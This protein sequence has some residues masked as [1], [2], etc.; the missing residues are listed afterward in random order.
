MQETLIRNAMFQ[1]PNILILDKPID[2]NL[3]K[4]HVIIEPVEDEF[5]THRI[6]G[7]FEG[8]IEI[9]DDFDAPL[10]EF[11]EYM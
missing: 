8:Q 1:K 4:V 10:E 6:L 7:L 3:S 2:L 9:S 5:K 11:K